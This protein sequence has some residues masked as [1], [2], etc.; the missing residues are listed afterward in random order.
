[1]AA[2]TQS[3]TVQAA[4]LQGTTLV[5]GGT[6]GDDSIQFSP[7]GGD[8]SSV[9][10]TMNGTAVGTFT[11]VTQLIAY[12][13]A[14]DDAISVRAGINLPAILF[15]GDGNDQLKG[16]GGNNILVGGSG[17]DQLIGGSARDLL[18][19]GAGAD[20]LIGGADDDLLIAG[21]TTY[22]D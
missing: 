19:G 7:H 1:S 18:I 15:G 16:G 21:S 6:L 17:D 22:D 5:G 11:G 20:Q 8:A 2:V 10:V 14:G 3:V 13:Q 12:G 4:E 9:D